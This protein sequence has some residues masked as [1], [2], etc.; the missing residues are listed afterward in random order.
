M[1]TYPVRN[2]LR[3]TRAAG[4][5]ANAVRMALGGGAVAVYNRE[6]PTNVYLAYPGSKFQIEVFDPKRG[7]ARKLVASQ[8]ITPV[9]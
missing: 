7:E 1:A 5:G 9:R 2:A 8:S 6:H 3:V 4:S